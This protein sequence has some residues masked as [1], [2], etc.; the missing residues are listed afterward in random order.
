MIKIIKKEE[1][2]SLVLISKI[3]KLSHPD[4]EYLF[5][6]DKEVVTITIELDKLNIPHN[7]LISLKMKNELLSTKIIKGEN[8]NGSEYYYIMLSDLILDDVDDIYIE[9]RDISIER[10]EK[11]NQIL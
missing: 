9:Y 6:V 11:L 5:L 10:E 3:M 4:P 1:I 2:P 8:F 7:G